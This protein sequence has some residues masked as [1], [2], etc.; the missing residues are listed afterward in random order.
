[1]AFIEISV[2]QKTLDDV[3]FMLDTVKNGAKKAIVRAANQTAVTARSR[4]VKVT[5]DRLHLLQKRIR[6]D[7]RVTKT[8]SVE[9]GAKV[10]ISRKPI[11]LVEF[12]HLASFVGLSVTVRK[13]RQ[14]EF[15]RHRFVAR[16]PS[17]HTGIFERAISNR[18]NKLFVDRLPI[19]EAVGPAI[20]NVFHFNDEQKLFSDMM[21]LFQQRVIERAEFILSRA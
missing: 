16:M 12:P 18:S 5:S 11:P 17:G 14:A 9:R 10:N 13:T 19:D 4:I 1:M 3:N 2:D 21:E 20:G 7:T 8:N 6:E 15:Y